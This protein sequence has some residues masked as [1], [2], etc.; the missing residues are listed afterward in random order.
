M[1]PNWNR[2]PRS[3]V[4][5]DMRSL[6]TLVGLT[7]LATLLAGQQAPKKAE[8]ATATASEAWTDDEI[9]VYR[10]FL[11]AYPNRSGG[12]LRLGNRTL[13]LDLSERRHAHD[14]LGNIVLEKPG[15]FRSTGRSLDPAVIAGRDAVLVDPEWRPSAATAEAARGSSGIA[16]PGEDTIPGAYLNGVLRLS[17]VAF[18]RAHRYAVLQY[19]F[20][21][22]GLCGQGATYVF[23]KVDGRWGRA[24]NCGMWIA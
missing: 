4:Y 1:G 14:C 16:L 3:G 13:P 12:R 8:K 6:S 9:A 23:L 11:A 17:E 24:R 10:A 19:S 2:A 5:S 22:G 20:I 18:D 15:P 7:L 21:C